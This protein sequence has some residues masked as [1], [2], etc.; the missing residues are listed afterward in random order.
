MEA[1]DTPSTNKTSAL[2]IIAIAMSMGAL[3]VSVLEVS[4]I[5]DDQRIQV[6][7]YIGVYTNYSEDGFRLH[8]INK[9]IGPARVQTLKMFYD[10]E[11]VTDIDQLILNTLG[12]KDAFS[13][14]LYRSSNISRSV[15]SADEDKTLF[16]VPWEP[17]TRRLIDDWA[18]KVDVVVC[19][20][21]VYDDCWESRLNTGEP[22]EVSSC[23][24]Q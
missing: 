14:D 3:F 13:Y 18:T 8:A 6:W 4:A 21:S 11:H 9:G 15:M 23:P 2:S 22:T 16:G 1:D 7:P 24:V 19:Y 17:R 20:C 10:G 5:R 12:E